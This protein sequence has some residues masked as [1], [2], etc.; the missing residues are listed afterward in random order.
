MPNEVKFKIGEI[1]FE[2][3]GDAEL[4]ER[5]RNEFVSN[6]LPLAIEAMIRTKTVRQE[7]GAIANSEQYAALATNANE[8]YQIAVGSSTNLDRTSISTF[9]KEKRAVTDTDII[10]CS[11]YFDEKKNNKKEFSSETVKNLYKEARISEPSNISG[12]MLHLAK[13][14]FIMDSPDSPK[15]NPKLY[16]LSSDGIQYVETL[17][18]KSGEKKTSTKA[19]KPRAKNVS[20]YSDI[21]IDQLNLGKYISIKSLK[22]FKEKMIMI[23]YILTKEN[24]GEW[25]TPNDVLCI[26]T[27]LFGESVTAKQITG[28]F[29]REKTWFKDEKSDTGKE[30]KH[31][32]LNGAKSFAENLLSNTN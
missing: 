28:V 21:N 12:T 20:I 22:T 30:V 6:L 25:F 26:M 2:A 10:M 1:E 29:D 17:Q 14:G 16:V 11:V 24:K 19:R 27:D 31:K 4:I 7:T 5:E 23:L 9:L 18:P 3:K 15:S 8:T 32:L 13:K